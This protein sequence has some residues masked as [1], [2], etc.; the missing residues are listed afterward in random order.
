MV[1]VQTQGGQPDTGW[2]SRYGVG[3]QTRGGCADMGAGIQTRG[4]HPDI[5]R[6]A[7]NT[8]QLARRRIARQE[9]DVYTTHSSI[10]KQN[11]RC[12]DLRMLKSR[13]VK[14]LQKQNGHLEK[15]G[16]LVNADDV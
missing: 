12:L 4:R 7:T 5:G 2:V 14:C 10:Y 1:G 3:I 16:C 6:V 9:G 11:T 13:Y 8:G 15:E